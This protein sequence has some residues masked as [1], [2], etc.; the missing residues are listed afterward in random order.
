MLQNTLQ[1][2]EQKNIFL[3][4]INSK[5]KKQTSTKE[6]SQDLEQKNIFY[7]SVNSKLKKKSE[8]QKIVLNFLSEK[9]Q[10]DNSDWVE[11]H[12]EKLFKHDGLNCK[13]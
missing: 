12:G 2:L 4:A 13:V 7:K 1:D 8:E 11:S 10:S 5:L 3:Q 6:I 9:F